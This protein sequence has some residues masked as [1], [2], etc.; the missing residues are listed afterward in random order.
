MPGA[1]ISKVF[2]AAAN[3]PVRANVGGRKRGGAGPG[4]GVLPALVALAAAA[5]LGVGASPVH[6]QPRPFTPELLVDLD[7]VSSPRL[8][9]DGRT[10]AYVVRKA[11]PA[12]AT[13]SI[14]LTDPARPDAP[15]RRLAEGASE[16]AW[17]RDGAAIYFLSRRGGSQQV[18][19]APVAGGEAQPMT[20]LPVDVG[21]FR[22]SRDGQTLV[23]FADVFP[24]CPDLACTRARLD[25][26]KGRSANMLYREVGVRFYDVWEDGLR[27]GLFAVRLGGQPATDAVALTRDWIADAPAKPG[28]GVSAFDITPDGAGVVFASRTSG[29]SASA[30]AAQMLYRA[31]IDGSGPPVRV[32][33]AASGADTTPVFSPDGRSLAFLHQDKAL[34]DG[35]RAWIVVRDAKGAER[36]LGQELDRSPQDIAWAPDGRAVIAIVEDGGQQRLYRFDLASGRAT[37]LTGEGTVTDFDTAPGG[38]VAYLHDTFSAPSQVF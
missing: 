8:S 24:D 13:T 4:R 17:S 34:S 27:H 23:L 21:G 30:T 31:P 20:R 5:W 3:P 16:P 19:R 28:G 26:Q 2:T 25:A 38:A 11:G 1:M 33:P 22:L 35:G 36:R 10:L 32:D 18:W 9:P 29:S 14:L 6:A 12:G 37:P 15:H 7:R